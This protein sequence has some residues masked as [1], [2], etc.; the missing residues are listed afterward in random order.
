[1]KKIW[2][3][4]CLTA[5]F[6][7]S[8]SIKPSVLLSTTASSAPPRV[9]RIADMVHSLEAQV[10]ALH[11]DVA[12]AQMRERDAKRALDDFVA[13]NQSSNGQKSGGGNGKDPSSPY[14]VTVPTAT[15]TGGSSALEA[16]R[17]AAELKRRDD[18]LADVRA[19]LKASNE[20]AAAAA[21]CCAVM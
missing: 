18:E 19:Q 13:L 21:P 5:L 16:A 7:F 1:M 6:F 3:H 2:K 8:A 10:A 17:L 11:S 4:T 14:A 12:A 20:K 15:G 9:A